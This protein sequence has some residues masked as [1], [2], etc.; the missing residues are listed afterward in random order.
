M[1]QLVCCLAL[2]LGLIFGLGLPFIADRPLPAPEKVCAAAA[3]GLLILY[4]SG[5]LIYWTNVPAYAYRLLPVAALVLVGLRRRACRTLFLDPDARAML[6]S[7]LLVA[8]WSLGFLALVRSYSGARWVLDWLDHYDRARFFLQH[9]PVHQLLSCGDPLAA[10]PPFANVVTAG[11]LALAGAGFP[12]FQIFTALASSLAF[13]PGWLFARQF[14]CGSAR[15]P[16][17]FTLLYLLNPA[18]LENTTFAWTKMLTVFFVLSGLYFFLPALATGSRLRL[19]SAFVLLAASFLVHYSAGPYAIALVTAYLWSRRHRWLTR[20]FWSEAILGALPAVALLATWF[21]WS[22]LTFGPAETF[23][24]NT[25]VTESGVRSL[26]GFAEEKGLNLWLTLV[27]HFIRPMDYQFI[28][29]TSTLGRWRDYFFLLYQVNLPLL[30]GSAGSVVLLWLLWR[31]GRL[32]APAASKTTPRTFWWWFLACTIV[33][34][35]AANGGIDGWGVAHLCLLSLLGLG[36]AYLAAGIGD[37]PRGW[38]IV[39]A[40]G[41][42]L[43][44]ALGVVLQFYLENLT[45]P[46]SWLQD[47]GRAIIAAHGGGTWT[48][49]LVKLQYR[50]EFVGDWPVSRPLLV[51]LLG[52]LFALAFV[53]WRRSS[54][55]TEAQEE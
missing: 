8:G 13:L 6:G 2:F 43:D 22:L 7:Y 50:L 30:F 9:W 55:V 37:L 44:F 25:S 35:T 31:A 45:F 32:T 24:S 21:G 36:L 54:A 52:G 38:R 11:F 34:G 51:A 10:R 18:V 53:R 14:G 29:Q 42:A 47:R 16:A 17:L 49:L 40:A 27:P 48:N 3:L 39:L 12:S 1:L 15:V 23:L 20:A 41:V 5:L 19:A 28:A 46:P 4:V 33:L 26:A